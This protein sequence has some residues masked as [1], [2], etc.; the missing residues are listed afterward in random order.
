VIFPVVGG[1]I[2]LGL[3]G[4]DMRERGLHSMATGGVG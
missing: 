3:E 2:H 4:K 1:L